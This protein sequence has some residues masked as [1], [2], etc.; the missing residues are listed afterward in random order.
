MRLIPQDPLKI[1]PAYGIT[2][3][4]GHN[5]IYLS[6]TIW[7][8]DVFAFLDEHTAA[9]LLV[10]ASVALV[11][12]DPGTLNEIQVLSVVTDPDTTFMHSLSSCR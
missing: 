9:R 8:R 3:N 1:F 10:V 6:I 7:E 12:T 4:E 2:V 11:S 5:F